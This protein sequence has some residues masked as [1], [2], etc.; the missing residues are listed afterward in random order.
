MYGRCDGGD[1]MPWTQLLG[2][3]PPCSMTLTICPAG[4]FCFKKH[5]AYLG[6][7]VSGVPAHHDKLAA[8]GL[9]G[10]LTWT[11]PYLFAVHTQTLPR[12]QGV[13]LSS[14]LQLGFKTIV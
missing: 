7:E 4:V 12:K 1:S 3:F 2:P 8:I 6:P 14:D 5:P 9:E 11:S 13:P 10:A